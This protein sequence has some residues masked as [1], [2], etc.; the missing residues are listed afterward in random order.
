MVCH[1]HS[2]INVSDVYEVF[3]FWRDFL[4]GEVDSTQK[5]YTLLWYYII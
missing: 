4:P 5:V 2:L 3:S 1:P